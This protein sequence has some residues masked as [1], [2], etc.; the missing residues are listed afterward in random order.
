MVR[1]KR[2]MKINR[3]LYF[4]VDLCVCAPVNELKGHC[5]GYAEKEE[6]N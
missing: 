6:A 4:R 5:V 3:S 1:Q 2:S